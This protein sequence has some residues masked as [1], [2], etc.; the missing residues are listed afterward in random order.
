MKRNYLPTRFDRLKIFKHILRW[1]IWSI[2]AI[3][4]LTMLAVHMPQTQEFLGR[5]ISALLAEKLNTEV[6]IGNVNLGFLNRIII[7]DVL[8]YDQAHKEMLRVG[9][10]STKIEYLPLA[11]GKIVISSAQMFNA[12]ALLYKKNEQT[13]AN[14][15]FVIDALSSN[16]TTS[17]TPLNLRVN[18][19]IM[20]HS[21]VRYDQHD[22]KVTPHELNPHHLLIDN[23]SA[24]IIVKAVTN[25]SLNINVKRLALKEQSGL[26]L[27]RFAMRLV[28]NKQSAQMENL[29]LEFP[30]STLHID[31]VFA[32][33][34]PSKPKSEWAFCAR[35]LPSKIV[36]NELSFLQ[37]KL[38]SNTEAIGIEAT[39][40]GSPERL[41]INTLNIESDSRRLSFNA[42]GWYQKVDSTSAWHADINRM[43]VRHDF[44]AGLKDLGMPDALMRFDHISMNG[45]F[46]HNANGETH[47]NSRLTTDESQIS[48]QLHQQANQQFT[49]QLT[50]NEFSLVKLLDNSDFGTVSTMLNLSGR[51]NFLTNEPNSKAWDINV[52]GEIPH[53]DYRN[54]SYHKISIDGNYKNEEFNG[55]IQVDDQHLQAQIEG[56]FSNKNHAYHLQLNGQLDQIA[57]QKL[58]LS[59][60]WGKATF[61]GNLQANLS[62]S[63]LNDAQGSV[64]VKDFVMAD[65]GFVFKQRLLQLTSG[66]DNGIHFLKFRGDMGEGELKGYFSWETL[67]R[68]FTNYIASKLPTLPGLSK[69]RRPTDNNFDLRLFLS[70]T[71]WLNRIVGIPLTIQRPIQLHAN[72]NGDTNELNI[73]GQL[74]SFTYDQSKYKDVNIH[75]RTPADTMICLIN[76][77]KIMDNGEEMSVMLQANASD[78]QLQANLSWDNHISGIRGTK[79]Q[80]NTIAQLFTN[81]QD[82]PEVSMKVLPSHV[83]LGDTIWNVAPCNI[84]Y[85]EKELQVENFSIAHDKQHL[86]ISGVA[87]TLPTDTLLID[88]NELEVA[89]ILDLVNFHSVDFSGFATG[90]VYGVSLFDTPK[91]WTNLKVDNFMFE[92]GR[93]GTLFAK[94]NWN[95]E[96]GQIDIDAIADDGEKAKTL[97]KGYVSPTHER[98]DLNIEAQ[99]TYIDFL[100]T[101][102]HSFLAGT[103]GNAYGKVELVGPLSAMDLIGTLVVDGQA[104][105]KALGTTYYL[106]QDTVKLIHDDIQLHH[107]SITD[108][109]GNTAYLSGGIHHENLSRLTF[110]LEVETN[111]LLAYDYNEFGEDVFCGNVTVEGTADLH[112]RPGEVVINCNVTP[113]RPTT[114]SYNA[115]SSDAIMSQEFISWQERK[116]QGETATKNTAEEQKEVDQPTDIYMNLLINT[117][118]QAEIRL[119][120]DESTNDYITLYGNGVIRASYHNKGAFQMFGTYTV[121]RGTY[122]ITIQ[123][124]IKKNFQFQEGGTITFGG[125][126]MDANLQ[127]QTLYTV[128]GVSLSDLNIG[129][130]FTNNTIRVNCLMNIT[131]NAGSPQ[132][133]FDLDM[134]TV[135]SE[136]KQMIRSIITTEQEMNQQVLYLLGIGRFYTQ[137]L[138]N[139]NNADAQQYDRTS[140]AMQSFL[141]GTL[142]SQINQVI[143]HVVRNDDW[144]FGANISTGNEGWHNAEYEGVINGR[145]LNNRLLINGQFGYRDNAT[146][147]TPSFIGDFDIRYLLYPSGNLALKVYNQTNDRY[148]THSALNT[149]GIGLIIKKD[150]NGIRDLFSRRKK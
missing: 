46:D 107:A 88:M 48:V 62:A 67:P 146:Q 70:S 119:L 64:Q 15:Q 90:I 139:A 41:N 23:L 104:T 127:L 72:I 7:D 147:A 145:M 75:M 120:M 102:S 8:I 32:N 39:I 78:N 63:N 11:E 110:D 141:S 60:K 101:Y 49:A 97:I 87:S 31:S 136:E 109:Y 47:I 86:K 117:N 128:N 111:R 18:S 122:G 91:A 100:S 149:Q 44:I 27:K 66:Y 20:R 116:A 12:Q 73:N 50:A 58:H 25:D 114:F 53:F 113:L 5:K 118:P 121:S 52:K 150:F 14:Y 124:I 83:V 142:S 115:A 98:I 130:S 95:N 61:A 6:R 59:D 80:L 29:E 19:F 137:D 144:N 13:P 138:N 77:T 93:M 99:G 79:G 30:K 43:D 105:V 135:N 34:D 68:S 85:K 112:G 36:L 89:Y 16:D 103:T 38:Q 40:N 1:T 69:D 9:R 92:Y 57:P 94:A 74:A 123:N 55:K 106:K 33:Y 51:A 140:L 132:V 65:S 17:N 125:N 71:E 42:K 26:T 3:Y 22:V 134:P 54:Y 37:P 10:L 108:R 81:A 45:V 82:K 126:P 24:H 84:H 143:S 56:L 35:I 148:F 21:R 96:E 28:A 133:D 76:A 2:V 4:A 129:N 131:G